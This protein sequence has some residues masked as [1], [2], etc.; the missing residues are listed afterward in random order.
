MLD[1]PHPQEKWGVT[2]VPCNLSMFPADVTGLW[3]WTGRSLLQLNYQPQFIFWEHVILESYSVFFLLQCQAAL[4]SELMLVGQITGFTVSESQNPF[5]V[6]FFHSVWG[7]LTSTPLCSPVLLFSRRPYWMSFFVS[8][9][10]LSPS[11][12]VM[13]GLEVNASLASHASCPSLLDE[14]FKG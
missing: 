8:G 13:N 9:L 7:H 14:E 2:W 10:H 5:S 11:L 3:I 1:R 12:H 6:R 4:Q